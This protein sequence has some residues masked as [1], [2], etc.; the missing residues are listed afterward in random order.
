MFQI[1]KVPYCWHPRRSTLVFPTGQFMLVMLQIL[2]EQPLLMV[3]VQVRNW[4]QMPIVQG[5]KLLVIYSKGQ[6]L[7]AFLDFLLCWHHQLNCRRQGKTHGIGR[8]TNQIDRSF[9]HISRAVEITSFPETLP[10]TQK[11]MCLVTA[12][13]VWP[14][15]VNDGRLFKGGDSR[16]IVTRNLVSYSYFLVQT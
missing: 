5:G 8:V 4:R 3:V 7:Y 16:D 13:R 11:M 10:V 2:Q 15:G 1:L 9:A 12:I 6:I 14:H